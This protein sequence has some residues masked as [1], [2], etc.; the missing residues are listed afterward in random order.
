MKK[1]STL[2]IRFL[3]IHDPENATPEGAIALLEAMQATAHKL[4]SNDDEALMAA[5][6]VISKKDVKVAIATL[7]KELVG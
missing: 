4:N 7:G 5:Y 2:Q 3:K 1:T 6:K